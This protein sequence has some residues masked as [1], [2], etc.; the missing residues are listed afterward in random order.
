ME[1]ISDRTYVAEAV[2]LDDRHFVDCTFRQ[3]RL[4]Y[5][6]GAVIFERTRFVSCDYY[7]GGQARQTIDVLRIAG[8]LGEAF[9]TDMVSANSVH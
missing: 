1:V 2:I 3:C 9:S 6:G 8:L 4:L 5:D 7:F